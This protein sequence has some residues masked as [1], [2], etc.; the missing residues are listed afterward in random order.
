MPGPLVNQLIEFTLNSV[1]PLFSAGGGI[2][3][4]RSQVVQGNPIPD[5]EATCSFPKRAE[6]RPSL[7]LILPQY[8]AQDIPSM[9]CAD[10]DGPTH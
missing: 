10:I 6:I 2:E 4:L 3:A 9:P 5:P 8:L 1:T 7:L